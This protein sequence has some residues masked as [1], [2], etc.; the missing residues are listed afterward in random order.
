MPQ[1]EKKAKE[2][3]KSKEQAKQAKEHTPIFGHFQSIKAFKHFSIRFKHSK[4]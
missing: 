1:H 3:Q 4:I 2:K